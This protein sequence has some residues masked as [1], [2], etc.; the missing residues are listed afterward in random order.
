MSD[1]SVLIV[2]D[3]A[4]V[5][6]DIKKTLKSLGYHVP[7]IAFSGEQAVEMARREK[8]GLVLMDILLRGKMDGIQAAEEIRKDLSIPVI[9]LTAYA[10]KEKLQRAKATQPFGYILKPFES[11]ELHAA[12]EI[13]LCRREAGKALERANFELE[14]RVERRTVELSST[15]EELKKEMAQRKRAEEEARLN[16]EKMC[17]TSKMASLGTLVSGMAHEVNNPVTSIML[18]APVVRKGWKAI[19]PVLE[20][21]IEENGMLHLGGFDCRNL[22]KRIPVLLEDI[23]EDAR[24][25]K[26]LVND[27][28]EFAR[29]G[30]SDTKEAVE[31]NRAVQ[32]SV[33][34]VSNLLK[35]STDHFSVEYGQD[36]PEVKGNSQRLEQVFV[37]LLI[38]ACQALEDKTRPV[39]VFT[40]YEKATENLLIK[41]F[42]RGAGMTA[43]VLGKIKDPFFTTKRAS[44]GTGLGLAISD[45]IV[46]DHGGTM[47]FDSTSG[48]GTTVSVRLP[49]K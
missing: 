3:E 30:T 27:L 23:E 34:L 39:N 22:K 4:V 46:R 9:Y 44:G 35:K 24:R 11:R 40:C 43:E 6:M 21:S 12:I 2:E 31:I 37:N 38:N 25:I 18:N 19:L 41:I 32:K 7:C 29:Q 36:L 42:D 33:G 48:Q 15:V 1:T 13:A 26:V 5:A 49:V 16:Q 47:D 28:K 10:D 45:K 20:N 8:P 17:Q 14:K